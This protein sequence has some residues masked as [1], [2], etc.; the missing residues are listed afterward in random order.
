LQFAANKFFSVA[1]ADFTE[2]VVNLGQLAVNK[3]AL[4]TPGIHE[5]RK[6]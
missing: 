6:K 1:L 2:L 3:F 4:L 5:K